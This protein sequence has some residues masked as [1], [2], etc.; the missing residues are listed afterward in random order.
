MISST[1]R[2][3]NLLPTSPTASSSTLDINAHSEGELIQASILLHV[4]ISVRFALNTFDGWLILRIAWGE[5]YDCKDIKS[6]KF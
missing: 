3:C 2:A 5:E 1:Q 6:S 4:S